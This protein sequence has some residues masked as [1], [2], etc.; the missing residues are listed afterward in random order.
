MAHSDVSWTLT[1]QVRDSREMKYMIKASQLP[2]DS[3]VKCWWY[4]KGQFEY[5]F[6]ADESETF[7]GANA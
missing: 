4:I 2:Y 3:D 6:D 1:Q 7:L 5:F